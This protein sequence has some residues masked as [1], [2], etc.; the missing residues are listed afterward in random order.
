[1]KKQTAMSSAEF[2]CQRELLGLPINWLAKN[3]GVT[4]R[5]IY[6]WESGTHPIPEWA[7]D[8][9]RLYV[10]NTENVIGTVTVKVLND[11][12]I[13]FLVTYR[14]D[15]GLAGMPASWHRLVMAR[16]AERTGYPIE[17]AVDEMAK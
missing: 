5:T 13:P 14:E 12:T 1:M 2:V 17:W 6:R 16:V 15:W 7:A 8:R 9:I 3:L 4:V 10:K 11:P